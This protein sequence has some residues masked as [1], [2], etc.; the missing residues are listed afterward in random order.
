MREGIHPNY[1]ES[2]IVCA[3]GKEFKTNSTKGDMKVDICSNCHPVWTGNLKEKQQVE[4]QKNSKRNLVLRK[5][6][7]IEKIAFTAI[8]FMYK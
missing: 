2:T 8:F 7:N 1:N 4:D 6:S 5:Q 3:C